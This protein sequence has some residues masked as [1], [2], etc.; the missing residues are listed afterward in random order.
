LLLLDDALTR[1]QADNSV[2][3]EMVKLRVFAGL[4]A[5]EAAQALGLPRTTAD[6]HWTYGRAWLNAHLHD[7]GLPPG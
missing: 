4:S 6:R 5:D 3:A 7:A 2:A 1:L